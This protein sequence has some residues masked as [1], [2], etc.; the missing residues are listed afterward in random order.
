M[1]DEK[2]FVDGMIIK[3]KPNAPQF[4]KCSLSFKCKDFTE[5]MRKHHNKGWLNVDL[6][7]SKGGKLYAEVDTWKPKSEQGGDDWSGEPEPEDTRDF[8]NG[9]PDEE[10]PF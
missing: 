7:V 10:I 2:L 9:D 1:A 8:S 6:K 4:V 3:K 5:F